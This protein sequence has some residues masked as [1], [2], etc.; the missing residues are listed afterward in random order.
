[1]VLQ[2]EMKVPVWG[3]ADAGEKVTISVCDQTKTTETGADGRWKLEL[4]PLKPGGPFTMT[5]KGKNEL[6][7]DNVLVGDVWLCSG[8]S[9]MEWSMNASDN[10]KEEIEKSANPNIRLFQV[11]KDWK[12]LPQDTL[13]T[14]GWTQ[15]GPET[16]PGFTAVGYYFGKKL[17]ADLNVPIGLINSSWGGT[18]IEPWT[19]PD[20]FKQFPTLS[21]ISE[22]IEAKTPATDVHKK[23][24]GKTLDE[25]KQWIAATEK[26]LSANEPVVPPPPFPPLLLPFDN[27]QRPT[28]LHNAMIYPFVPLAMKGVIWYQGESNRGEGMLYAE[29]MKALIAGWRTAFNNPQLGFYFVQLAPYNYGNEPQALPLIWEAQASVEKT[30]PLTGMAVINDIGNIKDIHPTNKKTVGERLA[31]LAENRTYGFDVVCASPELD[32][33]NVEGNTM[34]LKMKNALTL[35]TRDGKAPDWFEIAGAD[36]IYKKAD[37]T[38][39]GTTIKL[40]TS[41]VAKPYAVRFAWDHIAEPNLQNEAGL[42][43]GAF[44]AGEIPEHSIH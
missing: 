31:L 42:P 27:H 7:L 18:R 25:Y 13:K 3:W 40:T 35:K 21:S 17:N 12:T 5:V 11:E 28:V 37:A 10:G 36:G 23:I 30:V 22:E 41:S 39:E 2:R 9:N 29:K 26:K 14:R 15:S 8:Q 43:L 32:S 24:V 19:T 6:K 1:M 33:I 34:T 44:R 4:D 16:T 20:G 38:I